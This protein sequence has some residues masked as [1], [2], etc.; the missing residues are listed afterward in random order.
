MVRALQ[1]TNSSAN[2]VTHLHIMSSEKAQVSEESDFL[3]T[4]MIVGGLSF[5]LLLSIAAAVVLFMQ[6][7]NLRD[8]SLYVLEQEILDAK[9]E[10]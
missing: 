7:Q 6:L 4:G 5:L 2:I 10:K 9:L 3:S 1:G 8:P